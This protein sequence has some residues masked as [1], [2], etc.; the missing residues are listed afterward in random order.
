MAFS[1]NGSSSYIEATS[2]PVTAEPFTMVCW[3]NPTNVSTD[4]ALMSIGNSAGSNRFQMNMNGATGGDTIAISSV[5]AST[6]TS[7]STNLFTANTWHHAAAVCASNASRTIYL[8]GVQGNPNTTPVTVAGV[9][10]IM[11]GG[12]WQSGNRGFFVNAKIAEV[13]IWNVVLTNREI[14]S[15]SKG[16]APYLIRPSNLKFY[17]R[18]IQRSWDLS[19]SRVLTQV[20]ITNFDLPR[21]YG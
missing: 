5:G 3:F 20:N 4:G 2:T 7:S 21:I 19:G 9:N 16:F 10:N 13:A 17:N 8:N 18:C 14:T 1:F 12:R 11:I 15:L 6:A